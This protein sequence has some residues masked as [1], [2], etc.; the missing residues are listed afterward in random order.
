MK[1]PNKITGANA[2]G[3]RRL[4]IRAPWSARV[5]QFHDRKRRYDAEPLR[6]HST[7]FTTPELCHSADKVIAAHTLMNRLF[8]TRAGVAVPAE[9]AV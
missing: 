9:G 5:A 7:S 1:Q 3:P 2:G 4:A 6:K 8:S